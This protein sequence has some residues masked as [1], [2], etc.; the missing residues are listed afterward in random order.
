MMDK[1]PLFAINAE[2]VGY[3]ASLFTIFNAQFMLSSV[4]DVRAVVWRNSVIA[5]KTTSDIV[6]ISDS[7]ALRASNVLILSV[8]MV[9]WEV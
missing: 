3:D 6:F 4:S 2:C 9:G 1:I 7:F 5:G 8:C